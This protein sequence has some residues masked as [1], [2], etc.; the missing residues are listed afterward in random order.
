MGMDR[1]PYMVLWRSV[2][3]ACPPADGSSAAVFTWVPRGWRSGGH[4]PP[5]VVPTPGSLGHVGSWGG[6]SSP[7]LGLGDGPRVTPVT[8]TPTCSAR[9][10]SLSPLPPQHSMFPWLLIFASP[11]RVKFMLYLTVF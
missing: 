11:V 9:Q 10:P 5:C 1:F 8:Q 4:T 3:C 7:E 2:H 6:S